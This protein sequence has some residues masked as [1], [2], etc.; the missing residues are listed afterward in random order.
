MLS[1]DVIQRLP[2]VQLHCHLEGTV[3]PK[4]FRELAAR[5]K[6][7]LGERGV[8]PLER[9]Y[10]F[11]TF[12]EFL[13]LF[14]K[15]CEVLRTPD[16]FAQIAHEYATDAAHEGVMYAEL[17]IA[18]SVWK[19][20][21]PDLNIRSTV[22]AIRTALDEVGARCGLQ[23]ALIVDLTRNF[24]EARA[25]EM[26]RGA[27]MLQDLGVIGIGLGGDEANYPPRLF[28]D[29]YDLARRAGLRTVAHAGEA[30]G[31]ASVRSAI[32]D[33]GV[34]RIGHGIRSVEDEEL[35]EDLVRRRVPLEICPT[36][37]Y[38]TGSLPSGSTHPLAEFDRRGV[39]CTI[40]A[41][42]PA[43]FGTTLSNEYAIAAE[44]AGPDALLRFAQNAIDG[45]FAQP[46]HKALLRAKLDAFAADACATVT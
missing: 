36:S 28:R 40:D 5:G 45:S 6:I 3:R 8:G 37:N 10:D 24:G 1:R 2:K 16:D 44:L 27:A 42:D 31:P 43:L 34:E 15:V 9:C 19:H 35:L 11:R 23:V 7:E 33:L 20:F 30:A 18:P 29:V 14:G 21:Y 38:L 13:L 4:T 17:F 41:D 26:V 12:R 39:L 25:M 22:S 46:E 32:E